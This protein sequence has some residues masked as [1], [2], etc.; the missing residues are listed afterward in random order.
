MKEDLTKFDP[1]E[2]I[3]RTYFIPSFIEAYQQDSVTISGVEYVSKNGHT[4]VYPHVEAY[5]IK[6]VLVFEKCLKINRVTHNDHWS[7]IEIRP[8]TT[9]ETDRATAA[10]EAIEL[11]RQYKPEGTVEVSFK[12]R[13]SD[14]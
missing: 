14:Q 11:V 1:R 3:G 8:G 9:L 5:T 13:Y 10:E 12:V 7:A 2:L 6:T 4:V